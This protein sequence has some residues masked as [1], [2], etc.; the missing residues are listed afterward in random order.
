MYSLYLVFVGEFYL[1][2][3]YYFFFLIFSF[4]EQVIY[5]Q[6]KYDFLVEQDQ[7]EMK[8]KILKMIVEF[9]Q[10]FQKQS[11]RAVFGVKS[12]Y[13]AI[14]SKLCYCNDYLKTF[15]KDRT[16]TYNLHIFVEFSWRRNNPK[17]VCKI[18]D[19]LSLSKQDEESVTY[20]FWIYVLIKFFFIFGML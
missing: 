17:R 16:K 5:F 2:R 4:P 10:N 13:G 20:R 14:P 12:A 9:F 6:R 8:A 1:K 15:V 11:M 19:V 3:T 7:L 18:T